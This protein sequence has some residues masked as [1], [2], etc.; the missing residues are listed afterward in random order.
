M[1]V[2]FWGLDARMVIFVEKCL[3]FYPKITKSIC[4]PPIV[5]K[6]CMDITITIPNVIGDSGTPT[7]PGGLMPPL[8]GL[9][10]LLTS[11]Q[12]PATLDEIYRP[13]SIDFQWFSWIFKI[14]WKSWFFM[15]NKSGRI[16]FKMLQ[17][18]PG[19]AYPSRHPETTPRHLGDLQLV[20]QATTGDG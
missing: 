4:R 11:K 8:L 1:C 18:H 2:G 3:V 6:T 12:R 7:A 20:P 5:M 10:S 19:H 17:G 15:Q 13:K 16:G 9:I 14:F